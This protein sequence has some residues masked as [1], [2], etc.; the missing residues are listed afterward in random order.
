MALIP[1][2]AAALNPAAS[3]MNAASLSSPRTQSR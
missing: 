3:P 2:R 1:C